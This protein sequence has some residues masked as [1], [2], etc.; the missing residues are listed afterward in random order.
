MTSTNK[1]ERAEQSNADL[2]RNLKTLKTE[3]ARL[4]RENEFFREHCINTGVNPEWVIAPIQVWFPGLEPRPDGL[5][6]L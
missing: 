4:K 5:F 2:R 6:R 1:Q 3:V